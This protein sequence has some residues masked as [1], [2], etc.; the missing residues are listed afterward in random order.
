M[1]AVASDERQFCHTVTFRAASL[2]PRGLSDP[3][4]KVLHLSMLVLPFRGNVRR[5][6]NGPRAASC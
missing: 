1:F 6:Q 4:S 3:Q 2:S 5:A